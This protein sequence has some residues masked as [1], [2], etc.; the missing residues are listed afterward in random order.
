[1]KAPDYLHAWLYATTALTKHLRTICQESSVTVLEQGLKP[2]NWWERYVLSCEQPVFRRDVLISAQKKP[3]WFARTIIPQSTFQQHS[4]SF[5]RLQRETITA[6]I[7]DN[8][9]IKREHL[10]VFCINKES[11]AFYWLDPSLRNQEKQLWGRMAQYCFDGRDP[12]F[13]V[14]LFLSSMKDITP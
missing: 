3:Y 11:A 10:N 7:Y 6:L 5:N 13:I 9:R 8:D 1:M 12:F 14:E 2:A 4:E